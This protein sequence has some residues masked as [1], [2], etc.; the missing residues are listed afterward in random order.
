MSKLNYKGDFPVMVVRLGLNQVWML[1]S[2]YL[3]IPKSPCVFV[4]IGR[5]QV[6]KTVSSFTLKRTVG[7]SR[8]KREEKQKTRN[9]ALPELAEASERVSPNLCFLLF[10]CY[11]SPRSH[12]KTSAY[13][14]T[15]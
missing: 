10:N 11:I 4:S 5:I 2:I 9:T 3:I 7:Q 8:N 14:V 15:Y 1:E 13:H 12:D 6:V